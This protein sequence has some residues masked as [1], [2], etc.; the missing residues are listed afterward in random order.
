MISC[1][2][3]IANHVVIVQCS[4]Q[5]RPIAQACLQVSSSRCTCNE[6]LILSRGLIAW[7]YERQQPNSKRLS[8]S[9]QVVETVCGLRVLTSSLGCIHQSRKRVSVV[10]ANRDCVMSKQ[11]GQRCK[12]VKGLY[13]HRRGWRWRRMKPKNVKTLQHGGREDMR[14]SSAS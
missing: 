1:S 10:A 14:P 3:R 5:W 11:T 7:P 8:A 2:C 4:P 6:E 13:L 9:I 12:F